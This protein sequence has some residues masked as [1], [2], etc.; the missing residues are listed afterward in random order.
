MGVKKLYVDKIVDLIELGVSVADTRMEVSKLLE[1]FF[2]A[3]VTAIA[4]K[5]MTE[6]HDNKFDEFTKMGMTD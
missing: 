6:L 4:K 2:V 5:A 3:Q 1:E